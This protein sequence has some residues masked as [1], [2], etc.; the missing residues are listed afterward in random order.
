MLGLIT[1]FTDYLWTTENPKLTSLLDM[2]LDHPLSFSN[3]YAHGMQIHINVCL[4]NNQQGKSEAE[5]P[6]CLPTP[7]TVM[8]GQSV[9]LIPHINALL[10]WY[11]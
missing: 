7:A 10:S 6:Q 5:I 4:I 1:H 3:V 11:I 8:L 2:L 9:I